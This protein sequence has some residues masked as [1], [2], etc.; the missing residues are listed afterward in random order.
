MITQSELKELLQYKDGNL[1]WKVKPSKKT[2]IGDKAGT[3]HCAGYIHITINKKKYLA[4]RLVFLMH[5]GFVPEFIDHI[6][7]NR[8]NNN[9]ENLRSVTKSQNN[10]NMKKPITN[11]SGIKNVHWVSK[12][13]KWAVQFKINQKVY[14]C[15]EYFDID[16][17]KF[18][19]D[20]CRNKFHRE[21]AN[22]G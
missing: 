22:H 15:G 7:G 10:M 8:A 12:S 6:D 17:A 16:Y 14:F 11:K 4:H 2:I 20:F 9:I 5:H 18:V 1:Y 13:K 19:A 21:Y 3:K